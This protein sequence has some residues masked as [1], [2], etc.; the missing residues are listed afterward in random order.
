MTKFNPENKATLTYGETLDPAMKITD[1]EDAK[2]YKKAYIAYTEK[3]LKNGVSESGLT[4]EQI[5]NANLGYY[6][7]YGSNEQRERVERLFNC[8]HPIF[9]SIKNNGV[10]TA[11]EA[12]E[13]GR[14]R[15]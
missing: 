2:Q 5:V 7:G 9:G 11:K 3:F 8:A 1:A 15:N 4:A 14:S 13:A 6:A 12:Y 10:P